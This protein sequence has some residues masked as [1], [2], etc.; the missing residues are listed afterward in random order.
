MITLFETY[1]QMSEYTASLVAEEIKNKK[2]HVLKTCYPSQ[3]Q[4]LRWFN[5]GC[6]RIK[7]YN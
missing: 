3:E 5:W 2:G 1:E 6:E 7:K 4:V